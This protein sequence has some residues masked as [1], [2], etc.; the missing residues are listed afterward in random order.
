MFNFLIILLLFSS[1]QINGL[2]PQKASS[3]RPIDQAATPKWGYIV[4]N[5]QSWGR[6]GNQLFVVATVMAYGWDHGF[7]PIFT[8]FDRTDN[9]L[10]YNKEKIFFRLEC[11]PFPYTIHKTYKETTVAYRP[12]PLLPNH[13]NISIQG[14]FVSWKHFDHHSDTLIELFSPSDDIIETLQ[15]KYGA[16]LNTPNTVAVH[17][18]TY[19]KKVH[20][21]GLPF[22]GLSYYA[23]AMEEYPKDSLFV[24]FSDRINWCRHHFQ[25][26]FPDKQFIFIEGNDHIE[27][28]YLMSMMQ[29]QIISNSTYSWWAAYLNRNQEKRIVC[30]PLMI[31]DTTNLPPQDFYHPS[32]KMLD[33]NVFHEPYPEDIGDFDE[34]TAD[35]TGKY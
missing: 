27:D 34:K 15:T 20:E 14:Q 24:I 5:Q 12:I 9:Q 23:L 16:L 4:S 29:H 7:Q 33:Y 25:R 19:S 31:S 1:V 22:L 11:G 17:V 8:E 26:R 3:L 32:W 30:P 2:E 21:Q 18:R 6:L 28:L 13:K 35:D 10:S